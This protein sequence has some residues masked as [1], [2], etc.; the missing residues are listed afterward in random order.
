MVDAANL[1]RAGLPVAVI[2]LPQL[3]ATVG[4]AT[5]KSMNIPDVKFIPVPGDL[6]HALDYV[7][8]ESSFWD[9][10]VR[11]LLPAVVDALT[12]GEGTET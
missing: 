8:D 7:P 11:Q 3:L 1:E 6:N 10:A 12:G 5:A 4:R 9:E 2:G